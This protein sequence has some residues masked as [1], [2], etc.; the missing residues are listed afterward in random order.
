MSHKRITTSVI[1]QSNLQ[2]EQYYHLFHYE[3]FMA[4]RENGF[5]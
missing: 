2:K 1:P 5:S 4:L 3:P